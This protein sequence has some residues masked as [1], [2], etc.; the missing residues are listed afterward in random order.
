MWFK[1]LHAHASPSYD[2][3]DD[4]IPVTGTHDR[5]RAHLI[6]HHIICI[7]SR[8]GLNTFTHTSKDPMPGTATH[9][10]LRV[11]LIDQH[12]ICIKSRCGSYTFT[13]THTHTH[14]KDS[15]SPSKT[16]CDDPM[17][18]T[19]TN[20]RL[21]M[22]LIDQHIIR[23]KSRCGSNTSTHTHQMIGPRRAT[24]NAM[25]RCLERPPTIG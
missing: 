11:H 18:G 3:C 10:P 2:E 17:P 7:K 15:A 1:H 6:N 25:I 14:I 9:H 22:H 13:H 8:C 5:L 24:I 12:S 19:G 21:R 20:H 16:R 4:P 23:I